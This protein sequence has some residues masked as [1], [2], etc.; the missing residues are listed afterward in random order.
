[1]K[2]PLN[3][4]RLGA[5]GGNAS[6]AAAD[7]LPLPHYDEFDAAELIAPA[8]PGRADGH[9]RLRARHASRIDVLN[10]LRYMKFRRRNA[11][12]RALVEAR[13]HGQSAPSEAG[14]LAGA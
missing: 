12:V 14:S 9:R 7:G 2:N 11:V 8:L 6:S 4:H 3:R 10:K 1:M 5:A 13:H